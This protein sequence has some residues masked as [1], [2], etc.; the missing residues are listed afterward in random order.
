MASKTRTFVGAAAAALLALPASSQEIAGVTLG[1]PIPQ[2]LPDPLGTQQRGPFAYALWRR[3]DG[4]SM[5]VTTRVGSGEVLYV[6]LWRTETDGVMPAPL[7]DATFGETTLGDL[8]DRFGSAGFVFGERG[9]TA[10]VGE[11]AAF[12]TSYEIAESD[13]VI[14]FVTIMPLAEAGP[15]TASASVLDAVILGHGPY[16]DAIWGANRG[17]LPGYAPIPDPTG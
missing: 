3:A 14:S 13:A 7:P 12:F 16:L 17:A 4:V 1:E 8:K 9:R 5:S 2:A 10:P 11:N 15:E 6:E